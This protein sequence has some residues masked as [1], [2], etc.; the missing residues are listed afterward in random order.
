MI[1]EI[2][3]FQV[4]TL[5]IAIIG[6]ILGIINTWYNL[7]K[8]RVKLKVL[9][10]HAF[11]IGNVNQDFNFCISVTNLSSFAITIHEI[12][13]LYHDTDS[14]GAI[15]YPIFLDSGKWPR[16]LEPR[17]S[18]SAYSLLD[19]SNTSYKIKCAYAKTECGLMIKGTSAALNEIANKQ[20]I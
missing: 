9:P 15:T 10:S 19:K 11:S 17:T 8:N 7:D 20:S 13:I 16:K 3:I 18:F 6:A 5:S 12:G 2:T 14:R 1:E 4:V